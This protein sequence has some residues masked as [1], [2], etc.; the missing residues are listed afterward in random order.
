MTW[1]IDNKINLTQIC[2]SADWHLQ[3][4]IDAL[5]EAGLDRRDAEC[6]AAFA[7]AAYAMEFGGACDGDPRDELT[8][9]QWDR[10]SH[11]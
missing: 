8:D 9:D 3:S 2:N 5:A 7:S 10:L 4:I 6:F 11:G 1:K